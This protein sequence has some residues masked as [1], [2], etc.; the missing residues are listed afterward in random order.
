MTTHR[1]LAFTTILLAAAIACEKASEPPPETPP[2]P[3]AV[4]AAPDPAATTPVATP[5]PG[6]AAAPE[7][8]AD[9]APSATTEPAPAASASSAAPAKEAHHAAAATKAPVAVESAPAAAPAVEDPCQTKNFHFSQI[10]GACHSGGRKA[11]K[12]VMKGVVQKAK[13][14]GTSLTCTSCH[15]D[16]RDFH[17]K[18]NAVGDL[19]SF[20]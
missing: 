17:L 11:A 8:L 14:A 20:L 1:V 13:A 16:T 4:P 2:G 18:S 9:P 6:A 7:A 10:A 15:E 5:D 3:S 12:G 19:K